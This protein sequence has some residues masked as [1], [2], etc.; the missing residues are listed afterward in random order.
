ME[1]RDVDVES[2]SSA[3]ID[4]T[5]DLAERQLGCSQPKNLCSRFV[6]F[7]CFLQP[8]FIVSTGAPTV[9]T[10]SAGVARLDH[11]ADFTEARSR[12]TP[13]YAAESRRVL[14]P[15]YVAFCTK[16]SIL[17]CHKFTS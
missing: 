5:R 17:K 12:T 3:H 4:G 2:G 11:A 15:R 7:N 9:M 10:D 1:R 14:G 6:N 13:A 16:R 8:I